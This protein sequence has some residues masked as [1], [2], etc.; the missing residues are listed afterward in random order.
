MV[1]RISVNSVYGRK[2]Y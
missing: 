1:A 2:L